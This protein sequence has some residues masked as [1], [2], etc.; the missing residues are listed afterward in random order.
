MVK[1]NLTVEEKKKLRELKRLRSLIQTK[2]IQGDL[3]K[4][5]NQINKLRGIDEPVDKVV[6]A[7]KVYDEAEVLELYEKYIALRSQGFRY[8]DI[9]AKLGV[10]KN[11]LYYL[12]KKWKKIDTCALRMNEVEWELT[13]AKE[14]LRKYKL[15]NSRDFSVAEIAYAL[16]ITTEQLVVDKQI[17]T[18]SQQKFE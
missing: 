1:V 12:Q 4:V 17:W 3:R 13:Q 15:Y 7:Y 8:C 5:Q 9:A 2:I 6:K 18:N 16:D 11:R 14:R 10:V